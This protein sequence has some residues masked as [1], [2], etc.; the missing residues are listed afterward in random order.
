MVCDDQTFFYNFVFSFSE[1]RK[2]AILSV[3]M[4]SLQKKNYSERH[5]SVVHFKGYGSAEGERS[6]PQRTTTY[7]GMLNCLSTDH[8]NL[9]K[10]YRLITS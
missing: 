8:I 9:N 10:I 5:F 6:F 3:W 7:S 2:N 1:H 4:D